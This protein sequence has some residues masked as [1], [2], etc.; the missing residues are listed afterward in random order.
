MHDRISVNSICFPG[1]SFEDLAGYWQALGARRV[2]LV[3][4]QIASEGLGAAQEALRRSDCRVETFM[5][6]FLFGRAL[7]ATE[8]SWRAAREDL[9]RAIDDARAL[10]AR[11][12][13]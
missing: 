3:S 11:S 12:M 2:S 10:G 6:P 7:E 13:Y 1:A 9:D 5:H 8:G 4:P